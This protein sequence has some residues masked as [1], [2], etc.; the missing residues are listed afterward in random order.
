MVH[1]LAVFCLVWRNPHPSIGPSFQLAL[2]DEVV[3]PVVRSPL[4]GYLSVSLASHRRIP[5]LLPEI[6]EPRRARLCR[7]MRAKA[8]TQGISWNTS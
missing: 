3:L 6:F 7:S 5:E 2:T 8:R 1:T 4:V